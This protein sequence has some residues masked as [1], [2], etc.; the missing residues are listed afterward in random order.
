MSY[1]ARWDA[2]SNPKS[3]KDY[4]IDT[5][6]AI[7]VG[8]LMYWDRVSAVAR[9]FNSTHAWTGTLAGSQAHVAENFIGCAM[10]AHAANDTTR[11]LTV[12]VAGRGVFGYPV[13]T[14][15]TFN[16]GDLVTASQD[17]AASLLLAQAVDKAAL[18][19]PGEPTIVA[20][21]LAIGK[22]HETKAVAASVID[23]EFA[24]IHE[25][26]AGPRQYLTS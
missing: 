26:G 15:A 10:S 23:V 21:S 16:I 9:P 14:A 6:E 4:P 12:R 24:G 18:G 2:M 25:A 22:A 19:D 17:P 3:Q 11:F 13:T 8:D 5:A 1:R 20:R 7:A